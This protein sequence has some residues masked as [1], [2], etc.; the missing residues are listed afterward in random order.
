[1][2]IF[3]SSLISGMEGERAVAKRA[4]ELLRHQAVMAEDFPAQPN[5]PQVACLAGV[6]RADLVVL[7]LGDRYG[8]KQPSGLSATHEEYRAAQGEKPILVFLH[9]TDPEA[10]QAAFIAEVSGWEQGL[11]REPFSSP[12]ELGERLTRA[13]HDYEL[14]HAQGPMNPAEL[15]SRS[16]G[17]LPQSSQHGQER[18]RLQLTIAAGPQ[19]TVLRPA[20]IEDP[21]LAEA[22]QQQ[23][24][25]GKPA[26]FDR[27]LGVK[28]RLDDHALVIYQGDRHE[29]GPELRVWPD[30]SVRLMLPLDDR[31]RRSMGGL[32][33]LIEEDVAEKLASALRYANWLLAHIDPTE[34]LTHVALAARVSGQSVYGW[35]TRAEQAASPNSGSVMGWGD[36]GKRT[37]AV[38]L[39]PAHM[40]RAAL[41]M[42][43]NNLVNDLVALLRRKWKDPHT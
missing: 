5:S 24:L 25:F 33:F 12:A 38:Q 28:T 36:D 8:A 26:I 30:G 6:R 42:S 1:M 4:V 17:L 23:A 34:R 41:T 22:L 35:R 15:A 3:L 11:F 40:K 32:P 7:I 37:Q 14:A 27:G 18:T 19:A 2:Q 21:A 13:L 29:D 20:A 31:E 39:S 43:A 16:F 9:G 10:E